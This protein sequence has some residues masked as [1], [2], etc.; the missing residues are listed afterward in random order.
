MA[1]GLNSA[2]E[3]IAY[4]RSQR[5]VTQRGLAGLIGV[6][7]EEVQGLESCGTGGMPADLAARLCRALGVRLDWLVFGK[8]EWERAAPP[9]PVFE[10]RTKA[11]LARCIQVVLTHRPDGSPQAHAEMVAEL[12]AQR[13]DIESEGGVV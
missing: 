5:G 6:S 3:R 13:F 12:F 4:A 7:V 2:G 1:E 9:V 11:L 10:E 8:G